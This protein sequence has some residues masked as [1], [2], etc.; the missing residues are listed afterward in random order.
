MLKHEFVKIMNDLSQEQVNQLKEQAKNNV[1]LG[2]GKTLDQALDQVLDNF[3][4]ALKQQT[5]N[6]EDYIFNQAYDG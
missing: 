1:Y 2:Y 5:N 6:K 4:N 3:I